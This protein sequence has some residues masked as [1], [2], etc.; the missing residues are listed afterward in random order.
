MSCNPRGLPWRALLVVFSFAAA[1]SAGETPRPAAGKTPLY[2]NWDAN[3]LTLGPSGIAE[4]VTDAREAGVNGINLRISN[5]GALNFRT[6]AGTFYHERWDAFGTDYDPLAALIRECHRQGLAAHVWFD[7]FEAAYDPLITAHPEFSPQGR[8]GKPRLAGVPCYAHPEVRRHMLDVV[9]ELAAYRP[10]A[11]F[12]CT[13][14][15]HVP[16]NQLGQ[17]HNGDSGFNPPVVRRYRD[18]YGVDILKQPFDRTKL[19]RLRGEFLIDFLVEARRRLNQAGIPT[20]VGATVGGRLQST[21][22]NLILDWRRILERKAAD[23]LLMANSRGEYHVFYNAA[24]RKKFAEIRRACDRAGIPFWPYIMSSGTHQPIAARVG[25]AGLLEY[26]PRQLDYLTAM[27]G[28]AVLIH[29][30]DLYS[31]DRQVR[32]ALW[33][34]AGRRQTGLARA[35]RPEDVLPP[36]PVAV[37][38]ARKNAIPGGDFE[39]NAEGPRFVQPTWSLGNLSFETHASDSRP[40]GWTPELGG[41]PKFQAVYDWK[42]MHGDPFS[43]RSFY[44]RASVALGVQPGAAKGTRAA[45]WTAEIPVPRGLQG[46]QRIRVQV[47]GESLNRIESVGMKIE[48][49]DAKNRMIDRLGAKAPREGTF[50]WQPLEIVWPADARVKKLR[51]RLGMTAADDPGTEGR[52]WFDDFT[53]EPVKP[54]ESSRAAAAMR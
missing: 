39:Q 8:P 27:G 37:L 40:A 46:D 23:R 1:T 12:F 54:P 15:S 10:D 52:V 51:V 13:K 22:P 36:D 34:A 44:G 47:H 25:F 38:R 24:G 19:G 49:L 42:V 45:A 48:C 41:N 28:D 17:P 33:K 2:L 11:V 4:L 26:V 21:G 9:D 3:C 5:K 50:A 14:S 31:Y 7:L 43:G 35:A 16:R 20:I 6:R 18:L 29:D 30:L 53:I 32:R